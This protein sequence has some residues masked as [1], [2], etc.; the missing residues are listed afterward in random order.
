M[1]FQF[2]LLI[3]LIKNACEKL[4]CARNFF[5]TAGLLILVPVQANWTCKDTDSGTAVNKLVTVSG[6]S[7]VFCAASSLA[8][9]CRVYG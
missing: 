6:V 1:N 4:I 2:L 8:K 5:N 9:I 3:I 7:Q